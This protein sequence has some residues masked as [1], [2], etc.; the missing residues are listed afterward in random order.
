MNTE[1]TKLKPEEFEKIL[2]VTILDPDGWNRRDP[3][4]FD[5]P[6]TIYEFLDKMIPS[7]V[8]PSAEFRKNFWK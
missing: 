2:G 8:R 3:E 4:D 6:I 5:R 1:L 7:T